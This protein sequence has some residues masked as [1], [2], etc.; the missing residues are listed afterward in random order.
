MAQTDYQRYC[1]SQIKINKYFENKATHKEYWDILE[2][3]FG[4]SRHHRR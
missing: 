4:V 3:R 2:K 1:L